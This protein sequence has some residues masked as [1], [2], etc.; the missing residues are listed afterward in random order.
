MKKKFLWSDANKTSPF[1]T[2]MAEKNEFNEDD[3][4][5]KGLDF[6]PNFDLYTLQTNFSFTP[7]MLESI[8]EV[9]GVEIIKP[10][11]QYQL[12]IGLSNSGFFNIDNIKS[13]IE[14][15]ILSIDKTID[16]IIDN[17]I[18]EQ[19][20]PKVA[21]F[22]QQ[23]RD[24]LYDSKEYWIIYIYPNG[25]LEIITD[26]NDGQ[27]YMEQWSKMAVLQ[28]LIDGFLTGSSVYD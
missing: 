24:S 6:G 15:T 8:S 13:Q 28:D 9:K 23:I 25:Q 17:Q 12:I 10:V 22:F 21:N 4:D 5:D 19:F 16:I 27:E 20:G 26:I 7:M 11:S 1:M 2:L 14:N 3:D 18:D